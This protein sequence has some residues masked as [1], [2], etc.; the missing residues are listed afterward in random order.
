MNCTEKISCSPRRKT[1]LRHLKHHL[2]SIPKEHHC[3]GSSAVGPNP[4]LLGVPFV[5]P[6]KASEGWVRLLLFHLFCQKSMQEMLWTNIC[7]GW[8]GRSLMNTG[9]MSFGLTLR[10]NMPIED[11]SQQD[12][13]HFARKATRKGYRASNND[14]PEGFSNKRFHYF[15]G[16]AERKSTIFTLRVTYVEN[17]TKWDPPP[18]KNMT[19]SLS[20]TAPELPPRAYLGPIAFSCWGETATFKGLVTGTSTGTGPKAP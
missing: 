6:Q 4:R 12:T 14:T 15:K 2:S 8:D 1:P 16:K 18:N 17:H 11:V 9:I 20:P 10:S 13:H 19:V 5:Q 3:P 7:T